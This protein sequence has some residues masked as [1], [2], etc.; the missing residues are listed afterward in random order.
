MR[1]LPTP[2]N[3]TP[4]ETLQAYALRL[5]GF[6]LNTGV[7]ATLSDRQLELAD[8]GYP[9][10]IANPDLLPTTREQLTTTRHQIIAALAYRRSLTSVPATAPAPQPPDRPNLGPMA[11]LTPTPRPQPPQPVAADLAF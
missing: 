3:P 2:D 11:R 9:F 5:L 4:G 7:T 8:H 6:V 1:P 10:A